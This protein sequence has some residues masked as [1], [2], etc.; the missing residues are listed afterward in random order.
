MKRLDPDGRLSQL[1]DDV[2]TS[3]GM[4]FTPDRR[5]MYYTDSGKRMIYLFDYDEGSGT[6]TNQRQFVQ[7]PEGEGIPDGMTVD[8]EGY[9]WSARWDGG[10][11][12]RYA[13]DGAHKWS[14]AFDAGSVRS[15]AT[16][17]LGDIY[18]TGTFYGAADLGGGLL[19]DEAD[20]GVYLARLEADGFC[21]QERR[22]DRTVYA[23]PGLKDSRVVRRCV[24]CGSE[25]SVREPLHKC[26][27]CGGKLE[28]V[29]I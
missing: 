5:Q 26:S 7:V 27:N 19:E 9:I 24:Y 13:P 22:E 17:D 15:M 21:H 8:A 25:Y 12:V 1:L 6:I 10:R 28:L 3:N 11:L 29:K 14:M 4:G 20:F 16:D 2:G 23:F 18:L